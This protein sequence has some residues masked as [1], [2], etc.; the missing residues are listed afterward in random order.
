MKKDIDYFKIIPMFISVTGYK[1][2]SNLATKQIN[3]RWIKTGSKPAILNNQ[4][5]YLVIS[6][7][8]YRS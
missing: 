5:S 7:F 8:Q 1:R 6:S 4:E 2:F 3:I